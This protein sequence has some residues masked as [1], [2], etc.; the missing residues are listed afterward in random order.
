MEGGPPRPPS[1]IIRALDGQTM[2]TTWSARVI[3]PPGVDEAVIRTAIE[4]ELTA[5]VDIF[6]PWE[7][8]SEISRFNAAPEGMWAVSDPLWAVLNAAMDLGDETNGAVDPTLGTCPDLGQDFQRGHIAGVRRQILSL[9]RRADRGVQP[10][11]ARHRP[12]DREG[13]V[14][15]GRS[16]RL[17]DRRS[18]PN[19]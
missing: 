11:Q 14:C 5:V 1:D 10:V 12:G 8:D 3:A 13:A 9:A 16:P 15:A 7:F 18:S 2:G 4:E 6:S 19:M 17:T